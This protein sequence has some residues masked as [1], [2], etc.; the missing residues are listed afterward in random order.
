[1]PDLT[2]VELSTAGASLTLRRGVSDMD[3]VIQEAGCCDYRA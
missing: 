3:P 1:M 2:I